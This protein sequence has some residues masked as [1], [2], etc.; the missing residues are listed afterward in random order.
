[1]SWGLGHGHLWGFSILH[2]KGLIL[3]PG[4]EPRNL[5]R[6][7]PPVTIQQGLLEHTWGAPAAPFSLFTRR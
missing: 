4:V 5:R 1:M 6:E 2:P 7:E 3:S